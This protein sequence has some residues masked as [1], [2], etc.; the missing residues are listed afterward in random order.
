MNELKSDAFELE[1]TP[2]EPILS[3]LTSVLRK[4]EV[5]EVPTLGLSYALHDRLI[6]KAQY[7]PINV[8]EK[9]EGIETNY[10]FRLYDIALSVVF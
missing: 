4:E 1:P 2:G 9:L 10:E 8:K 5:I 7:A 3:P 6:F